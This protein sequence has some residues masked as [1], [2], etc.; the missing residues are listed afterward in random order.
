[1]V[2]VSGVMVRSPLP[3]SGDGEG[4]GQGHTQAGEILLHHDYVMRDDD[5][6][7]LQ[8]I[9]QIIWLIEI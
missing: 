3:P 2:D 6:V 4:E 9:S 5:E 7:S 1:M 8:V